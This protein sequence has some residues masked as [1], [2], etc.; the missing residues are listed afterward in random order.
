MG[1][2]N[3]T[4]NMIALTFGTSGKAT[5]DELIDTMRT[6]PFGSSLM[7]FSDEEEKTLGCICI[8]ADPVLAVKIRNLVREYDAEEGEYEQGSVRP[9]RVCALR[10]SLV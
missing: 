5:V 1:L 4:M 2:R 9:C 7:T 6:S 8:A 3:Q 10:D